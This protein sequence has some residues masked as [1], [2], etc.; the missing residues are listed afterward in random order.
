MWFVLFYFKVYG[1][2]IRNLLNKNINSFINKLF[3]VNFM[4]SFVLICVFKVLV[5]EC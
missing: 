1:V 4:I 3:I 2:I 5:V